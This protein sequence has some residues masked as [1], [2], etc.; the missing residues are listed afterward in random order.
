MV[1]WAGAQHIALRAVEFVIELGGVSFQA[2]LDAFPFSIL[3]QV[4]LQVPIE[5]GRYRSG[6]VHAFREIAQHIA[7][8]ETEHPVRYQYRHQ[9]LEEGRI[10]EHDIGRPL[11]LV[12]GPVVSREYGSNNVS[13]IGFS[14]SANPSHN[15]AQSVFNCWSSSACARG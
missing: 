6:P 7:A 2:V 8:G 1:V 4:D 14:G 15:F 5:A 9:A 11:A 3:F 10:P 12:T 13:G